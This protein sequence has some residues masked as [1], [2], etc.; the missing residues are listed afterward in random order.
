MSNRL[1]YFTTLPKETLFPLF[2]R[3]TFILF[4]HMHGIPFFCPYLLLVLHS[5]FFYWQ[6]NE[7]NTA[8]FQ[9]CYLFLKFSAKKITNYEIFDNLSGQNHPKRSVCLKCLQ[10]NIYYGDTILSKWDS[11][12]FPFASAWVALLFMTD[13][14]VKKAYL[15]SLDY[16]RVDDDGLWTT[17][18]MLIYANNQ[19]EL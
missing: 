19:Y 7:L 17:F 11:L 5:A 13:R 4:I 16:F 15:H 1:F 6:L 2:M 10:A 12:A 3:Q 18:L 14:F 8:A 9:H